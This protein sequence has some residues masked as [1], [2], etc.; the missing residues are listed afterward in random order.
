MPGLKTRIAALRTIWQRLRRKRAA[1]LKKKKAPP[2]Y[3]R[4]VEVDIEGYLAAMSGEQQ[5]ACPYINNEEARIWLCGFN[6]GIAALKRW[7]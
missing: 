6:R 5:G 4:E 3:R 1:I 2:N 7:A